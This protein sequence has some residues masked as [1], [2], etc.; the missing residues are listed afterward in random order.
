MEDDRPTPF[1]QLVEHTVHGNMIMIVEEASPWVRDQAGDQC[2]RDFIYAAAG[3][4]DK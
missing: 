1:E 2:V 3:G 4:A